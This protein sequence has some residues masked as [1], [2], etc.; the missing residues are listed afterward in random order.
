[1]IATITFRLASES[2]VAALDDDFVW[3]VPGSEAT[4]LLLNALF[5]VRD[6]SPAVGLPGAAE[7]RAAAEYLQAELLTLAETEPEP[8]GLV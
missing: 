8:P 7:A 5:A 6:D 3:T 4:A 1:M 2:L